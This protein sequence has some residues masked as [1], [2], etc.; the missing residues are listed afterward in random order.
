[1]KKKFPYKNKNMQGY[2]NR[3]IRA[4]TLDSGMDIPLMLTPVPE[5]VTP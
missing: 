3:K 1:M 5:I 2:G 4:Y